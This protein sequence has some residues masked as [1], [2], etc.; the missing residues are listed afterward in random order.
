VTNAEHLRHLGGLLRRY[1]S[2]EFREPLSGEL[3][4]LATA[5]E[6]RLGAIELSHVQASAAEA[7]QRPV[8]LAL[9]W[10]VPDGS[11]EHFAN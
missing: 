9:V 4:R 6:A 1:Y 2:S 7:R 3:L 11:R 10:S 5:L 8:K